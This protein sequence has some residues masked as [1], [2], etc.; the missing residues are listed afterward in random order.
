MIGLRDMWDTM[1]DTIMF[2]DGMLCEFAK[3]TD[4]FGSEL[5]RHR[6]QSL[7]LLGLGVEMIVLVTNMFSKLPS[8]DTSVFQGF[9]T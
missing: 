5:L 1:T 7:M 8:G 2:V 3:R 9:E 6:G 4:G